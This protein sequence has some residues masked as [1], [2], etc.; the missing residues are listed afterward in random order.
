MLLITFVQVD[1]SVHS[2]AYNGGNDTIVFLSANTAM[3]SFQFRAD[4]AGK[5]KL[6]FAFA[7]TVTGMV[8]TE[9]VEIVA[10]S[11]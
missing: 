1:G 7:H 11:V 8:V 10:V 9:E 3:Q 5:E 6:L 4:K 2:R